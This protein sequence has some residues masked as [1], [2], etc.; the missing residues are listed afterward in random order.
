MDG[1]QWTMADN[2]GLL[3]MVNAMTISN[4]CQWV[5]RVMTV[6]LL[7]FTAVETMEVVLHEVSIQYP[8]NA[9]MY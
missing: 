8:L 5:R 1:L 2:S 6:L 3:T 9:M 4:G 7:P